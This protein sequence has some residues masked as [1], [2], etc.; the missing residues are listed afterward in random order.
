MAHIVIKSGQVIV[1]EVPVARSAQ[2]CQMV[3]ISEVKNWLS[4]IWKLETARKTTKWSVFVRVAQCVE[5]AE[6]VDKVSKKA[7]GCH[8]ELFVWRNLR[9]R[10]LPAVLRRF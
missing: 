2:V 8:F 4:L 10:L 7:N 1:W 9:E 5:I 3:L 6:K